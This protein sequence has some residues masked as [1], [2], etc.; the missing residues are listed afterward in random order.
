MKRTD[1]FPR[2]AHFIIDKE[3]H[4]MEETFQPSL[5]HFRNR[6]TII[7]AI[8]L[9]LIGFVLWCIGLLLFT[10]GGNTNIGELILL[11]LIIQGAL[12]GSWAIYN[13]Y[14]RISRAGGRFVDYGIWVGTV[15]L[16]GT[17]TLW[18]W[19]ILDVN[20][21]LLAKWLYQG[22]APVEYA[23]SWRSKQRRKIWE[24]LQKASQPA[25]FM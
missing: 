17:F 22:E 3:T 1:I 12:L 16:T 23:V 19:I 8:E 9:A 21:L 24:Q 11:F 6:I 7:E 15:L 2:F 4:I 25:L 18:C 13:I 14:I 10:L 5:P 20:R